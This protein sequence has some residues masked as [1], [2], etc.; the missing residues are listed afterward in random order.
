MPRLHYSTE[1]SIEKLR[2][3]EVLL[4]QGQSVGQVTRSFGI[5]E[6]ANCRKR[7]EDGGLRTGQAQRLRSS[8]RR[9]VT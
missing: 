9:T 3:A 8:S 5:S 2:E 6:Q 1:E 4:G 7:K